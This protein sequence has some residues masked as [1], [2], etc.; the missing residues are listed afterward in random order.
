MREFLLN[1]PI[2]LTTDEQRGIEVREEM[3]RHREQET[4]AFRSE[5]ES[6]VRELG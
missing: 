1:D 4:L 3:D 2:S 5:V 6:R